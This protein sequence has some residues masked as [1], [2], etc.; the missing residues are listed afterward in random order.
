MAVPPRSALRLAASV[1]VIYEPSQPTGP[2]NLRR[3]ASKHLLLQ[4]LRRY[5][6]TGPSGVMCKRSH[7]TATRFVRSQTIGRTSH[8]QCTSIQDVRVDHRC[9][10]IGMAKELLDC[11]NVVPVFEQMRGKRMPER[12]ATDALRD[13]SLSR[14][15]RHGTLH[16]RLVHVI[17]RWRSPPGVAAH[18]TR[19]KHKLPGPVRRGVRIL[20]IER[21]RQAP[22]APTP[23]ARS[24]SCCRFT[25]AR[26]D[27]S[28]PPLHRLPVTSVRRSLRPFADAARSPGCRSKS[29]SFTR[30]LEAFE[31]PQPG[32]I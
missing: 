30:K 20:P 18:P 8:S 14:G 28:E 15:H 1:A 27:V 26:C 29:K 17:S 19:R 11:A 5:A 3:L 25:S 10:D 32:A 16:R 12:M 4:R 6:A 31:Q 22:P 2:K 7:I 24:R 9:A 23:S 13:S 21:V